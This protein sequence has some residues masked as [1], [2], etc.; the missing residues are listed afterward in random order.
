M[1]MQYS[2]LKNTSQQCRRRNWRK[3]Y[4]ISKLCA[5]PFIAVT[6]FS[7]SL[8]ARTLTLAEDGRAQAAVVVPENPSPTVEYAAKELTEHI[9]K[10]VGVSLPVLMENEQVAEEIR[11]FLGPTEA[12]REC[13]FEPEKLS[14]DTFI[15]RTIDSDIFILGCDDPQAKPLDEKNSCSGTLFGVYDLL[16][17]HLGV[18]W[19]WPGEL[20]TVIPRQ[21]RVQIPELDKQISPALQF[22][23]F[24]YGRIK[25]ALRRYDPD[26]KRL[27]FSQEGLENYARDLRVYLRRHRMGL[28]EPKPPVGH[29]F[30]GWW[31]RYG[32]EHPEWFMMNQDGRRGDSDPQARHVS[33]CVS[34]QDLQQ[35]IVE[36]AW[37]GGDIL[38]LG[39]TDKQVFCQCDDCREWDGPQPQE[40]PRFAAELYDPLV[41]SDRYAR[42]WKAIRE[43]AAEKNPDVLVTTFLYW[44]YL[45]APQ[46]VS[47][48]HE[49][50][51][52]EF[53]PWG[54]DRIAYFPMSEE[55]Y[56][57]LREQWLGWH[58]TGMTMAYRPNYFHG[59]YVMPH[60]STWQSGRFL[61]FA[62]RHGMI[63]VDFDSLLG[64]WAT[65]GPMLYMHMRLF[66][67]PSKDI[68]TIRADY[69]DGF[70]PAAEA[71][72]KYFDYWEDYSAERPGGSLYFP[73]RVHEAYP[74]EVFEKP[75]EILGEAENTIREKSSDEQTDVYLERVEFLAAGL[76][77]ARLAAR[78]WGLAQDDSLVQDNDREA[79]IKAG[80]V[81]RELIE[82]RREHE[83]LYIADYIDAAMRENRHLDLDMVLEKQEE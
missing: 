43:A 73:T 55:A 79:L 60:I 53:V 75:Q 44:N 38:R 57:W 76:E 25:S 65:K 48:L 47:E 35:Y 54:E 2:H 27:A 81:L 39:G 66:V 41:V 23:R 8:Q 1:N 5:L 83:H 28:S 16:E 36:E 15:Q 82:F 51:Y 49:N 24:R 29:Y 19:L 10:A 64:H 67:D 78:G 13:G 77:H 21:T 9:E 69:F 56:E 42:F 61:Q 14:P 26:I 32:E 71:V 74:S 20:G 34:N 37:D 70:G 31:R 63:G 45:P 7:G 72:E 59:G 46:E 3:K 68:E 11:I 22:R 6:L 58:Q 12:A 18:R 33:M 4:F 50:I 30:S 17:E 52:G 62:Y 40:P 80:E